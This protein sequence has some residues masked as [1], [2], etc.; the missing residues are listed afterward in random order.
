MEDRNFAYTEIHERSF[1]NPTPEKCQRHSGPSCTHLMECDAHNGARPF[2][3]S[4]IGRALTWK[5]TGM[6]KRTVRCCACNRTLPRP[7]PKECP[8]WVFKHLEN[9]SNSY[10]IAKLV[11]GRTHGQTDERNFCISCP[12]LQ[13]ELITGW[14][15][16]AIIFHNPVYLI[17]FKSKHTYHTSNR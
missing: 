17:I 11:S 7:W 8:C 4:V 14:H 9:I 5:L 10:H 2:C 15:A 6:H 1:S 3:A 16:I 12:A 13:R